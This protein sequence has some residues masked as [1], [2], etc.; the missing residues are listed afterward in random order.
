MTPEQILF[1]G[2]GIVAA[3]VISAAAAAIILY[4]KKKRLNEKL[5]AEFGK[6]RH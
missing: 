4:I 1:C 5:T 6:K 2:I 3:A